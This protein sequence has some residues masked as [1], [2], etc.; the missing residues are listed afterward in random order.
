MELY[1]YKRPDGRIGFRNNVIVIP[2]TGCQ[3]EIARR[4]AASVPGA[5]CLGHVNGCDLAAQDFELFGVVLEHFAT[6][7]NVGGVLF[8]AMGCA[9]A[10]TLQLPRKARESGRLVETLNA[11]TMGTTSTVEAGGKIVR[12]M[13]DELAE[14]QR[15][16]VSFE[17]LVVGT[18]C[19]A[20]D[21][22]S[23][24][25]CHP[26]LGRA[27]D[28]LVDKGATV[29][30]S[31]ECELVPIVASLADRAETP[32]VGEKIREM[33]EQVNADWKAR[34]GCTLE[35]AALQNQSLEQW[36]EQS[37][38]HAAKAGTT[39]IKGFFEM[40]QTVHGPGLV[41]LNAPN[42]DLESVTA[43]AAAGCNVT[44]FTT[45]RGTPV[46]SP[47][48]ITVK[49]T[50]T[51]KTFERMRENIDVCVAGYVEGTA[52]LDESATQV[53]QAIV[54]SANGEQTKSEQL[55]H[56]EVAIPIRG[57]TY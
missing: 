18:K 5:T 49:L 33:A 37:T 57:V 28:M 19:G 50:A 21:R 13:V 23:F 46:G 24:T 3:V 25:H 16:Q 44:V 48:S 31:E 38:A 30:L 32:E 36:T 56:W 54:D 4:I 26:V 34:Y 10:L 35:E 1:G 52:S 45:G 22:V 29:V 41:V 17:A 53:V 43:L 8:L 39:P 20:S 12:A 11:Q 55:G 14:A 15:K 7:P 2:L 40:E 27:C 42:T 9:A 6:H 47:A 51:R